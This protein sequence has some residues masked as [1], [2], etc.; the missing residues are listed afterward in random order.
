[1]HRY[2]I[3]LHSE[4]RNLC[5]FCF[6]NQL[7][8][9]GLFEIVETNEEIKCFAFF[10]LFFETMPLRKFTAHESLCSGIYFGEIPIFPAACCKLSNSIVLLMI[11]Y[12]GDDHRLHFIA[13]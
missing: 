4:Q 7:V 9:T 6:Y 11:A 13:A 3:I 8:A 2:S 12:N 5:A 1:M 10:F